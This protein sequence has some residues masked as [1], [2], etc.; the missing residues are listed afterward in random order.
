MNDSNLLSLSFL[1]YTRKEIIK[2][3]TCRVVLRIGDT[4]WCQVENTHLIYDWE[5]L[6][7]AQWKQIRL[8]IMRWQL[9]SLASRSGLRIRCCVSCG[10]G[11]RHGSDLA[12]LW[13]WCG[14]V[15]AAPIG[16]LAWEP[17][18]AASAAPK[19]PSPPK[20]DWH[21]YTDYVPKPIYVTQYE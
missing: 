17:P 10:V 19:S 18:Y 8:G 6:I 14:P 20:N 12:L 15:A 1:S 11:C 4:M 2:T 21:H 5:V 3:L 9:W 7:V 13:L 16:P